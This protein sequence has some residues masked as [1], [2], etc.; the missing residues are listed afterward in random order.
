MAKPLVSVI[1]V[2]Y[3]AGKL[4]TQAVKSVINFPGIEVVVADNASVDQSFADLKAKIN[5]KNLI[6]IDNGSNLGFGRAVNAA[7][8]ASHGEYIYL[9][10]PDASLKKS[11]LLQMISTAKS[12]GN[13]AVVAPRLENPDGSAQPSCYPRQTFLNAVKE[14]W[15][16]Q[17]G[18]YSKYLPPGK[19]PIAVQAAVAAAWLVPRAVW[20]E[21]G[22]LSDRFFLYFEDLDFCERAGAQGIPIV[23]DPQ[24]VVTHHHGV[25]S[26]T[27]PIVLKLFTQS[28]WQYHGF[29]KKLAIDFVIRIRDLFLPPQSWKK[30]AGIVTVFVLL[31]TSIAAIGYFL[32]P[33][34]LG[35]S[36]FVPAPYRS[37]FLLW[38]SANFDGEH[39]LRIAS[40]GYQVVMGQSEYAFFPLYPLLINLVS[41][42][43]LSYFISARLISLVALVLFVHFLWRWLARYTPNPVGLS[44]LLLLSPGAV[45]LLSLYTEPLFLLFAVLTFYWGDNK[46]WGKAILATALA[47]ATRVNGIFLVIFLLLK[48]GK[49]KLASLLGLSGLAGYMVYLGS[50]TGDPLA[51]YRA[52]AG[53]GKNNATS[54]FSTL[55][56]YLRALTTEFVPDLTHL[57][58]AIE[59]TVALVLVYLLIRFWQ[60]VK[61]DPAY[62]WYALGTLALPLATGSLGSLPRFSLALFPLL[63]VVPAFSSRARKLYY[64][65]STVI[66]A[67]GIILFTR[68]YW[69]A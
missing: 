31:V 56:S 59:L 47:T 42:S 52:Q 5:S 61:I 49:H 19:K 35:P 45:F 40:E 34:R 30:L 64:V 54:P 20:D 69:Y 1:I 37:N 17:K 25:S 10:N 62:K 66:V 7:V 46:L 38:S 44:W 18:S 32:L 24:A 67:I 16:G 4:L 33:S 2:N 63:L 58:V 57:V 43:G 65:T 13:R 29:I 39:Y 14:Y 26:R 51:W 60:K 3:N 9:L 36:S 8:K 23:Y 50:V 12:W 6:L 48:M 22:G 53:W 15:L 28:A 11:A 21:L 68:G 55:T 27:N 41:L